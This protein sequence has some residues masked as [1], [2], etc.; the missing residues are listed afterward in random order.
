MTFARKDLSRVFTNGLKWIP[1]TAHRRLCYVRL[2]AR[3]IEVLSTDTYVVVRDTALRIKP[4]SSFPT[5][6]FQIAPEFLKEI[7]SNLRLDKSLS[8]EIDPQIT[9]GTL[10]E[11]YLRIGEDYVAAVEV[12]EKIIT[13]YEFFNDKVLDAYRPIP[14]APISRLAV[15]PAVFP[16]FNT[17][18]T[19]EKNPPLHLRFTGET[20]PV[21]AK[22][23]S[24]FV[25]VFMP[26]D[27]DQRTE[28]LG[29]DSKW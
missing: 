13:P 3:G 10:G 18:K 20:S 6:V 12:G 27:L 22:L 4:K 17:T 5:Q 14:E 28:P 24:T 26:L 19:D 8:D 25:A 2:D 16:R 1:S 9:V 23:G 11:G 15:D 7:E 29:D 21:Y